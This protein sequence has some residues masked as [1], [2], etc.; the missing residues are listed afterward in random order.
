MATQQLGNYPHLPIFEEQMV[1]YLQ[2]AHISHL[3]GYKACPFKKDDD[4]VHLYLQTGTWKTHCDKC[5]WT[6]LYYLEPENKIVMPISAGLI[7][8][9]RSLAVLQGLGHS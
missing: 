2:Q 4:E 9:T 3:P 7:K 5:L 1:C 6:Q 8:L